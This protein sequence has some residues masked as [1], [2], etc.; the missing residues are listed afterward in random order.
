MSGS[1]VDVLPVY[2]QKQGLMSG[3]VEFCGQEVCEAVQT[4]EVQVGR[5]IEV[6]KESKG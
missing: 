1:D 4:L 5:E 3:S 2:P 6:V